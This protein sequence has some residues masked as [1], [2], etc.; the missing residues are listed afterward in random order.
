MATLGK[1]TVRN[2]KGLKSPDTRICALISA[3]PKTG[4]TTFAASLDAFTRS[5]RGKP[6]LIIAVEAAEGGGTMSVA[7]LGVDYVMPSTYEEMDGLLASLRSDTTYGGIILDNAT[8]YVQRIVK[9]AALKFPSKEAD[10]G[11][12]IHGVP[13]R[14]DYQTMGEQARKQLNALVNLTNENTPANCRKDLIVTALEREK[15]DSFGNMVS[16]TPDF[17]GALAGAAAALFQSVVSIQVKDVPVKDASGKVLGRVKQRTLLVKP[18]AI[19]QVG[20]RSG[21]F[22]DGMVLTDPS[23]APVGILPLWEIFMKQFGVE[24]VEVV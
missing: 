13:L 21:I 4:K 10:P 16:V 11:T 1:L 19:R 22:Q 18:D 23:G 15:S 20:D 5:V 14:G 9:P 7:D 17:P 8:D 12:R 6:T 24:K 2:T 3:V